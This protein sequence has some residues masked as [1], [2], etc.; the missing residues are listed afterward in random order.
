[1]SPEALEFRMVNILPDGTEM[2][3]QHG[4]YHRA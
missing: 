3:A 4:T 2:W 1:V